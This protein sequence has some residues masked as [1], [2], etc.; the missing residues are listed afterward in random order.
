MTDY[1]IPLLF[2]ILALLTLKCGKDPYEALLQGASEGLLLLPR[3][4]PCLIALLTASSMLRASGFFDLLSALLAP[5]LNALGIS[6]ELLPLM[7]LQPLSGSGSM[8]L[9]AELMAVHGA[10]SE[11]G[12]MAAV[13]IGSSET[14]FYTIAVYFGA[15]GIQK[16]R[17]AVP[18]ALIGDLAGMLAAI[19]SVKLFF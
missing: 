8:A 4:L 10:D 16:S 3:L 14:T 11:I 19:V 17:Y 12:R 18:A 1:L 5:F 2:T 6:A 15:T 13:L 9:A 7:L